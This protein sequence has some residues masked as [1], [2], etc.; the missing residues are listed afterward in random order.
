M[1]LGSTAGNTCK[2]IAI[3]ILEIWS[4]LTSENNVDTEDISKRKLASNEKRLTP[5]PFTTK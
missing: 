2:A 5:S 1:V 3:Q 4:E